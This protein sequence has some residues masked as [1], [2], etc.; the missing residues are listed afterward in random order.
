M[1]RLATRPLSVTVVLNTEASENLFGSKTA[2]VTVFV[3]R[4]P[5]AVCRF[6]RAAD[7]AFLSFEVIAGHLDGINRRDAEFVARRMSI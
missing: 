5:A 4:T 2:E 7:G 6:T 1:T 3:N